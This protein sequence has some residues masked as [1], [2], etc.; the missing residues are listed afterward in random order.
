MVSYTI[1][2]K[3]YRGIEIERKAEEEPEMRGFILWGEAGDLIQGIQADPAGC[4]CTRMMV[5]PL[6]QYVP[7][8][9][10]TIGE[11]YEVEERFDF[12]GKDRFKTES[13][14]EVEVLKFM[15]AAY[16]KNETIIDEVW[17]S[18]QVPFYFVYL[19]EYAKSGPVAYEVI[20]IDFDVKGGEPYFTQ[21]AIENCL[22][23][24]P[25]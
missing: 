7:A 5:T 19:T 8:T 13:G 3:I 24:M 1:Q 17:I 22:Q 23:R 9:K 11:K 6:P 2:Q 10:E 14:K 25:G 21:E 4:I 18:P 12:I 16:V 20:L 15:S